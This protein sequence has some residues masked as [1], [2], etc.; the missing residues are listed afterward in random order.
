VPNAISAAVLVLGEREA[1]PCFR[2][3]QSLEAEPLE[4]AAASSD[5]PEAKKLKA[6]IE[7]LKG[8]VSKLKGRCAD[9][10]HTRDATVPLRRSSPQRSHVFATSETST[11]PVSCLLTE[12]SHEGH[13]LV[14]NFKTELKSWLQSLEELTKLCHESKF[15]EVKT[16]T[17]S[18][19]LTS[20]LLQVTEL[21]RSNLAQ[22]VI[23]AIC[24]EYVSSHI[25]VTSL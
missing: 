14:K 9:M 15:R 18:E 7:E 4:I 19:E 3:I 5:A 21:R 23:Q 6:E 22:S 16:A 24:A 25:L 20:S 1:E 11:E 2:E 10:N 17:L 12:Y 8:E 13:A